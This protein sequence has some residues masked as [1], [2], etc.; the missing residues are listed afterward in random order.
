MLCKAIFPNPTAGLKEGTFDSPRAPTS[1]AMLHQYLEGFKSE[2][3]PQ[4]RGGKIG[5]S[6]PRG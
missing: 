4:N 5:L 3:L 2:L 6:Y 1:A